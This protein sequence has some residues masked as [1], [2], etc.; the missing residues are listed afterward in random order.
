MRA[1]YYQETEEIVARL[2]DDLGI[3][4]IAIMYQDDSFGREGFRG[5]RGAPSAPRS[6]RS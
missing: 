6:Y 5:V 2:T 1:S 3:E 4:R